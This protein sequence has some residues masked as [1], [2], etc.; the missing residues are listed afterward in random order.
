M[1]HVSLEILPLCF[2]RESGLGRD[3]WELAGPL[4][5]SWFNGYWNITGME[6]VD[7]GTVN[8]KET[9]EG[10]PYDSATHGSF[11]HPL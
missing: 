7:L 3:G 2:H 9:F 11:N 10:C 5:V 8:I 1:E 4:L 6:R